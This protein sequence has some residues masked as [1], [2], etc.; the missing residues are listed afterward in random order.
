MRECTCF[1]RCQL[2][3]PWL[4]AGAYH[5]GFNHGYNCAESTNF[6]TKG[7][8]LT[9]AQAHPCECNNDSVK[10][11][12]SLFLEAA[13]PAARRAIL[14]NLSDSESSEDDE[15]DS[16]DSASD[17]GSELARQSGASRTGPIPTRVI[18][19]S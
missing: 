17:T 13:N 8:I 6:A 10:I 11:Q 14:A 2:R 19:Y 1:R 18:G 15:W 4:H 7:W 12:L 5:S 9:G 3:L 16:D